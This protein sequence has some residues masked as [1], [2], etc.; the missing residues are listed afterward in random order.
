[1]MHA[2]TA[3]VSTSHIA[4]TQSSLRSLLSLSLSR[5]S[6]SMCWPARSHCM[7]ISVQGSGW[8]GTAQRRTMPA[9]VTC[10]IS[11]MVRKGSMEELL[12]V[13]V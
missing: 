13:T 4:T 7:S 9:A 12:L 10:C 8:A 11:T 6:V 5:L 1:M 2:A 3:S